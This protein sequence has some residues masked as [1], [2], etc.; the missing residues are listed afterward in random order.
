MLLL[1][2][3]SLLRRISCVELVHYLALVV[4]QLRWMLGGRLLALSASHACGTRL[5]LLI[6]SLLREEL[7]L[8]EE[9]VGLGDRKLIDKAAGSVLHAER[10]VALE[11]VHLGLLQPHIG[12]LLLGLLL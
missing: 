4:L 5:C 12:C 3:M 1:Q 11:L 6:L 9:V 8:M 2:E 10:L 7:G